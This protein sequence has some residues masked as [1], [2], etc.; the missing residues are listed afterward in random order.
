[1]YAFAKSA[2]KWLKQNLRRKAVP[3]D[4]EQLRLATFNVWFDPFESQRRCNAVLSILESEAPDIVALEE[5][6][7]PF[8]EAV[9]RAP[10]VRAHYT[11]SRIKVSETDRY[12]V[13]ML[14][15]L[16][17][18]RFTAHTLSSDM[19]RKLHALELRT[20]RGSLV[21]AGIHLESMKDRA[22]MR[23]KQ[24][25]ECTSILNGCD[26]AIWMGDFNAAPGSAE[27]ERILSTF[28]DAWMELSDAPGYTRDTTCNAMLAKVKDDRHQR[29]DRI[30]WRGDGYRPASIRLLGTTPLEGS[31]G[32]VFPSDHFG[33]VAELATSA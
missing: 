5:V 22:P 23:L 27:D 32:Q 10:W 18:V 19:G 21:V 14:S 33:L 26:C 8:L 17:V 6:T 4:P 9:L 12:E 24:I 28:R 13:V 31:A 25:E 7:A 2:G 3:V 16:P 1:M 20:K 30:F 15:R 11:S 29:I